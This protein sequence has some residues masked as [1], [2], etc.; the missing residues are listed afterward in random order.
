MMTEPTHLKSK[1]VYGWLPDLPDARDFK[2]IPKKLAIG[3]KLPLYVTLR[4]QCPP[5]YDQG[6]IGSCVAQAVAGCM[7]FVEM[8]QLEAS[9]NLSRLFIYYNARA[10][11]GTT[12]SDSGAYI[13]DGMK[14]VNLQGA[15]VESLWQYIE[16]KIFTVP[17]QEC[18]AAA[19]E[20]KIIAYRRINQTLHDMK[21]AL[22]S[23]YP[24]TFGFS[25]YESFESDIVRTTGKVPM[26]DPNESLLGGHAVICTG[27][28][29]FTK[30]FFCRNS[31]G[32]NWGDK[33]YFT[34]PYEYLTNNNYSDDFW[35]IS[36]VT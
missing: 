30:R 34:M 12:N 28:H 10:I 13:R 24:F 26:P 20:H 19:P 27:Y 4:N 17:P 21:S 31:W 36:Q 14:T 8:K 15:C 29:D 25:V 7:Q 11:I 5:V 2:F 9:P 33:G 18:Y 32:T 1:S 35:L 23:G 3:K 6:G 22:A 16:S